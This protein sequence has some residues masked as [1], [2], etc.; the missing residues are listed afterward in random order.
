MP[1]LLESANV[2]EFE[3]NGLSV[4]PRMN[5]SYGG[6]PITRLQRGPEGWEW[7]A[8]ATMQSHPAHGLRP[9]HPWSGDIPVADETILHSSTAFRKQALAAKHSH[10]RQECRPSRR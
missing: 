8:F 7:R 3:P 10:G 4:T 6:S 1:P 9:P 2:G 5:I